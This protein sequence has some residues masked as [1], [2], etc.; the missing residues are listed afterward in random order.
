MDLDQRYRELPDVVVY[1]PE[2]ERA[3]SSAEA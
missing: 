2:V 3:F 1:D